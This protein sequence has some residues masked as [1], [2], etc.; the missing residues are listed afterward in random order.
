MKVYLLK[1]IQKVGMAGEIIT[2]SDGYAKNFIF[3]RKLGVEVT[4]SNNEFFQKRAKT[5]E[6]RK[7][8]IESVTS[9]LSEQIKN[10]SLTIKKKMHDDNKLYAS[11]NPSDIVD[12][13]AEKNIKVSKSQIIF[14]KSIKEAGTHLV[15]IKLSSKLQPQMTLKVIGLTEK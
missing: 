4:G 2:V 15:T 6:H 7:E 3:P 14:D 9:M 8:V 1:D 5:I 11:I 13:L 10:L 12:L